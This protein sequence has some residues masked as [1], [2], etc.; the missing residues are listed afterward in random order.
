MQANNIKLWWL[1]IRS[2]LI[3]LSI[4]G[5]VGV[6][7]W[8]LTG[9]IIKGTVA[10]VLMIIIQIS[11]ASIINGISAKRNNEAE[12]LAEQVLRE[13][14]ERKIPYNLNCAYCNQMNRAGISFNSENIFECDSCK[15]PNKVYI[16]FSTVR[17]TSPLA[18]SGEKLDNV[19]MGDEEEP[20]DAG[21]RQ[22]TLNDS[23]S[24][25]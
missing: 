11:L 16:Q 7:A 12:Y 4:S 22:T 25:S 17:L 6:G 21:V 3:T 24:V 19:D 8:Y 18:K 1:L 10:G 13:A 5:A 9:D 14:S 15:Q 20:T 2:I 23:I